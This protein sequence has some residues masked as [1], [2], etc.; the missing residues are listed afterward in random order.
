LLSFANISQVAMAGDP[1][2]DSTGIKSI[3]IS[4][5]GLVGASSTD[6][7]P[8]ASTRDSSKIKIQQLG[9]SFRDKTSFPKFASIWVF[10]ALTKVE[11]QLKSTINHVWDC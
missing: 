11:W 5:S 8:L 3:S 10:I 7:Q 9:F 6:H 4:A 2:N 1:G